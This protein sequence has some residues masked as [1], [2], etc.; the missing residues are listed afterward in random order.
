MKF[1]NR[2]HTNVHILGGW[3]FFKI[4]Q[5]IKRIESDIAILR[6]SAIALNTSGPMEHTAVADKNGTLSEIKFWGPKKL[7]LDS[8]AFIGVQ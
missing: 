3:D 1:H 4:H 5:R 2:H 6:S 7:L 8:V